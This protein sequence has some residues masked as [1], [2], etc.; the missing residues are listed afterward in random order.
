MP[1]KKLFSQIDDPRGKH[2]W[3]WLLALI[4]CLSGFV[5]LAY[6]VLW[7]RM[8]SMQFGVSIFGVVLAVSAFMAGLG[9]GSVSVIK[10]AGKVTRP[11]MI[12][13]I[14]EL[15]VSTYALLIPLLAK[16]TGVFLGETATNLS[17]WQWYLLE[18]GLGLLLLLVPAFAM[19]A[20]FTLVL[21]AI[22]RT[23]LSLGTI[24]GINTLGAVAGALFPL[25]SLPTLGWSNSIL[26]VAT[27]GFGV[28]IFA[29]FIS[30]LAGVNDTDSKLDEAKT[31]SSLL[32]GILLYTGIGV[33]SIMLEI[34][35]IRLFGMAL[36]RTEYV[37]AVILAA[38]LLGIALGSIFLPIIK[39]SALLDVLPI[40]AGSGVLLSI[41]LL[42]S[43]SAWVESSQF[44]TLFGALGSQAALLVLVTLPTT[45]ALGAW[46]PLLADRFGRPNNHG[47]WLYGANCIGGAFGAVAAC[48]VGIPI[49]GT[50]KT[51]IIAGLGLTALGMMWSS[52]R[53]VWVA[54]AVLSLL[55]IPLRNMPPVHSL[56]PKAVGNSQDLYLYEDAIA[57]THVVRL[58]DGQRILLSDLQRM[59]AS[60]EPSAVEIQK[61]QARLALLL[62]PDPRQVLFLG[63]GT[64]ISMAGSIPYPGLQLEAVEL[65]QGS[66]VAA[67]EW[68]APVNGNVLDH[69]QI[70]RDDAKHFLSISKKSYDVIIGDL[71]HPDIAGMGGLLSIQQFERARTRLNSNG[72][73][74]QWLAL[75]QFDIQ[76]LGVVLRSFRRV[77]PDA[78]MFM[79]GMHLALIGPK[80]NFL[81]ASAAL[82]NLERLSTK[83]QD[84]A[85][86]KEGV[87][88]WLGRYWGPVPASAGAVQDEWVPYIEFN[89]P[90]A[91]YKGQMDMAKI[92][93]SMLKLHA[94]AADAMKMLN[95]SGNHKTE[96]GRAYVASE[97]M[98]RSWIASIQEDAETAGRITWLAYQANPHDRWIASALADNMLQ[99]IAQASQH[100]LNERE[101]WQ[102]ILNTYPNHVGALRALWHLEQ[103]AGNSQEAERYRMQLSTI[104]P[105]DEEAASAIKSP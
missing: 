35:W 6:E 79:D 25:W 87:W 32:S 7:A 74:V 33:C 41:L 90:D 49:L 104:S 81:G 14:V 89:L 78:Q 3:W 85:T 58:Q 72:V 60:T 105:L 57:L 100:G 39:K 11:L 93:I 38:F 44:G 45:L 102:R 103:S 76:S 5:S 22:K 50:I 96:F 46:L 29:F 23:P 40:A 77:F 67:K 54:L 61:D 92:L 21:Q 19:G 28:G 71:F 34:G 31:S 8:L 17:V 68:F 26:F 62:H 16:A 12:F 2:S 53:K 95:I 63:V 30:F 36:L 43:L 80:Q 47:A 75:N 84:L 94:S 66:I 42:P 86:G 82:K 59:D 9:L 65:S 37:L 98:V 83:Q 24:Y 91:R 56:L 70:H 20:G 27:L 69:V 48:L 64:G 15:S 73:F 101:A 13:A 99:S 88:T 1:F 51:I 10:W 18:G 52:S 4:Y 55:A 97:L